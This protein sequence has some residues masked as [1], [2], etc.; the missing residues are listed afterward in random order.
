[1]MNLI[2]YGRW[3]HRT[4]RPPCNASYHIMLA[5]KLMGPS[6]ISNAFAPLTD[7]V[8]CS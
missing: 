2:N 1:M 7:T 3:G 6:F 4:A 8:L 5:F